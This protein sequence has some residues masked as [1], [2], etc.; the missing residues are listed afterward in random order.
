MEGA[1]DQNAGRRSEE[2]RPV[3]CWIGRI[4]L[5]AWLTQDDEV[6]MGVAERAARGVLEELPAVREAITHERR[7]MERQADV[8]PGG[9]RPAHNAL[10]SA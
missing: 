4:E 1:Y 10:P 5:R 6:L 2:V 8:G 9:R 3:L 7:G